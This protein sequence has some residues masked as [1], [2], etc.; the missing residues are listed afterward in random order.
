MHQCCTALHMASMPVSRGQSSPETLFL[1]YIVGYIECTKHHGNRQCPCQEAYRSMKEVV[2]WPDR[3]SGWRRTF[4]RN[5][6]LVF[7]PLMWNSY[8]AL[9]I[10]CIV[11]K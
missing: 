8:K 2:A 9:C 3:N 10:F 6:M 7:T 11:C 4:S 1:P 5:R